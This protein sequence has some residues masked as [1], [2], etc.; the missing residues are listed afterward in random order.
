M[1]ARISRTG[2]VG[3]NVSD[4]ARSVIFYQDVFGLDVLNQ[5]NVEGQRFAFLGDEDRLLLTLWEQASVP[6]DHEASGL[7]HLSFEVES[8]DDVRGYEKRLRERG[9][10]I[11]HDGIV[12]HGEGAA[13]GGLF[14]ADPDGTRLEVYAPTGLESHAAPSGAAPTCGF[15]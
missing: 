3:I 10:R 14:F 11:Y 7:H 2:H 9:A 8:L 5:S 6:Y 13:S 15:F 1:T 4:L 12:A